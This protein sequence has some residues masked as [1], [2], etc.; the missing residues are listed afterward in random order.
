MKSVLRI[1]VHHWQE[2]SIGSSE[3][4]ALKTVEDMY[5]ILALVLL[6]DKAENSAVPGSPA[7]LIPT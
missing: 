6:A 1:V 5:F 7:K 4:Q 3:P 2:V